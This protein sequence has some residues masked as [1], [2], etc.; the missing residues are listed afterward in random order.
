MTLDW[1]SLMTVEEVM[2]LHAICMEQHGQKPLPAN[3]STEECV[4][5]RLG[6]AWT[7][8]QY[9]LADEDAR[10][11]LCFAGYIL[12]Y[13]ARNQCFKDG[14]KRVAWSSAMAVLASI[15]LTVKSTDDEA[16]HLVERIATG[17]IKDGMEVVHWLTGRLEAPDD[18]LSDS[19]LTGNF[20]SM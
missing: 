6:N 9:L 1:H 14:N 11:G 19:R 18:P 17:V 5:G 10:P 8:E 13:L 15:G 4:E 7:S 2:R 16:V 20:P 3:Q 12:Y